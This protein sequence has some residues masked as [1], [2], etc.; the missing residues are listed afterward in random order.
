[1]NAPDYPNQ[2][3]HRGTDTS[4]AAASAMST[5]SARFQRMALLAIRAAGGRGLTAEEL[6]D[7][8]GYPRTTIQPRTTELKLAGLIRDSGARRHN[9][10]D[11]RAIVW[12]AAR[13][14]GAK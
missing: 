9:R 4:R 11:H 10:S 6:A 13:I 1:M 12:V 14:G 5:V 8:L 7:R 3:G 2:P